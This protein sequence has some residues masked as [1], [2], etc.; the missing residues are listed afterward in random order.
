MEKREG[1]YE[2]GSKTILRNRE[3][4]IQG[5]KRVTWCLWKK[6]RD[7][8]GRKIVAGKA[9]SRKRDGQEK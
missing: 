4:E 1:E 6:K 5:G 7:R 2:E 8:K 3:G 9:V